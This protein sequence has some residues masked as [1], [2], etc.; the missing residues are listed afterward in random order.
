MKWYPF[1]NDLAV[2]RVKEA[3][4]AGLFQMKMSVNNPNVN[5]ILDFKTQ[6]AWK[7]PP[8]RRLNSYKVRIY[9]FQCKDIPSADEDGSSDCYI[10]AWTSDKSRP[11]TVVIEDNNNPIFMSTLEVYTSFMHKD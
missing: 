11:K 4:M 5:G 8:P 7:K 10:Q 1:T 6:S 3:H 9:I 2:G